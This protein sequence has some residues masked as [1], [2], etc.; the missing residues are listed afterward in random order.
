[1][2]GPTAPRRRATTLLCLALGVAGLGVR[3][4]PAMA[5]TVVDRGIEGLVAV[6]E[7]VVVATVVD[8]RVR[9][10][11]EGTRLRVETESH[12]RV[13]RTLVG[14][15][16]PQTVV[17][18]TPGG[19]VRMGGVMH[20]H[21]VPGAAVFEPGERVIVFLERTADDRLVVAGLA[22]GKFTLET[23]TDGHAYARRT[24]DAE[25][26]AFGPGERAVGPLRVVDPPAEDRLG[27]GAL[28]ARIRRAAGARVATPAGWVP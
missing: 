20:H 22:L 9:A 2:H 26:V 3:P 16:T 13:E 7:R 25:R 5:T 1:M 14:S 15:P 19:S 6:S 24:V 17:L 21:R 12:L 27:A 18:T 28:I 8:V 11:G 4:E 10:V 23:G